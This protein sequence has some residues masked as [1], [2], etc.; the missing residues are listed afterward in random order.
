MRD[1]GTRIQEDVQ[2]NGFVIR[3]AC[4]HQFTVSKPQ[5][6]QLQVPLGVF[7]RDLEL[8]CWKCDIEFRLMEQELHQQYWHV[9]GKKPPA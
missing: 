5:L 6:M 7:V 3:L 4:G 2:A 8:V 9:L 1:T